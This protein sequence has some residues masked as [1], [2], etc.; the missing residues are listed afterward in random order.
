MEHTERR[1]EGGEGGGAA[2]IA[3]LLPTGL[4][5]VAEW[6]QRDER[7]GDPLVFIL[8][9]DMLIRPGFVEQVGF[10]RICRIR[11]APK[12]APAAFLDVLCADLCVS[13]AR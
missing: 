11:V 2:L 8:D 9:T 5:A 6:E 4:H 13:R 12:N 7:G 1:R 10:I 3:A